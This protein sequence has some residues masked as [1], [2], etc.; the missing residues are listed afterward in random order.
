MRSNA[1]TLGF[2]AAVCV[3]CSLVVSSAA[4]LLRDRQLKNVEIDMQKNILRCVGFEAKGAKDDEISRLY[5]E[6]IE[7]LV[8][9]REG[10]VVEGRRLSDLES[11]DYLDPRKDPAEFP[12]FV[13]KKDGKKLAYALPIAGKGLWSTLYG[14]LALEPDANTVKGLTFYKHGETPG[15]GAEVE[16]AWFQD[17]WKGK[18]ILGPKGRLVSVR[19]VKGK[20]KDACPGAAAV[21]CVDGISGATMTSNGVTKLVASALKRYEPFLSSLRR[22]KKRRRRKR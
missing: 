15:L 2:A 22:P 17:N 18:K 6:N 8:I 20:A 7:E 9:D 10:N 5:R 1:Y 12:L 21:H 3:S 13:R 16:K 4:I 14:Y 19:V 11:G